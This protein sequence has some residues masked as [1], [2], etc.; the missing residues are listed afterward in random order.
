MTGN[1]I[2][3]GGFGQL[4]NAGNTLGRGVISA[5][6]IFTDLNGQVIKGEAMGSKPFIEV[7]CDCK[8]PK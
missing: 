8:F 3:T 1:P 6:D 4:G 2:A 7:K 5:G